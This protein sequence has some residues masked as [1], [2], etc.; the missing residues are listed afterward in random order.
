MAEI[1]FWQYGFQDKN[2]NSL[3]KQRPLRLNTQQIEQ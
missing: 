3:I 2:C 1:K